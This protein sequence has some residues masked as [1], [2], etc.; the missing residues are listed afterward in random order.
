[1]AEGVELAGAV[2][3]HFNGGLGLTFCMHASFSL[4]TASPAGR[5]TEGQIAQCLKVLV[6]S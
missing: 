3:L 1:M 4:R 5:G 6:A 2:L